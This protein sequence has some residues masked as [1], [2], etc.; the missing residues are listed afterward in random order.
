MNERGGG[1]KTMTNGPVWHVRGR[2]GKKR[3][4]EGVWGGVGGGGCKGRGQVLLQH[5]GID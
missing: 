2:G 1:V 5:P 4:R 3:G